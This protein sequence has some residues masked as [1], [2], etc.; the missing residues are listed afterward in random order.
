MKLRVLAKGTAMVPHLESFE[1]GTKRF[2]G[3]KHDRTLGAAFRDEN[4]QEQRQGGWPPAHSP[5]NPHAVDDR[6]EYRQHVK[7][8][9]LW[10]A[11]EMTAAACGVKF[12][13]TFGG[14]Y[15]SAEPAKP[16]ESLPV[17]S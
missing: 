7:E 5:A 17:K 16:A 2:I 6:A 4:G 11:D 13:K 12:D 9:D 10:A 14:E 8:G 1:A 15:Q 3:R